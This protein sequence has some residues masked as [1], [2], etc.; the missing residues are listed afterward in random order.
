[1]VHPQPVPSNWSRTFNVWIQDIQVQFQPRVV[2][3][4][5]K[6]GLL[7][8]V[9][10]TVRSTASLVALLFSLHCVR[11]G[12][13]L[14]LPAFIRGEAYAAS[15]VEEAPRPAERGHAS[16]YGSEADGFAWLP[17]ASGEPCNPEA[18]TCAH[19][20]L[21]FGT[22]VEVENLDN[23]RVAILRVNDRGPFLA[24][25][26]ID[27]TARGAR[28]LGFLLAG[29]ARVAVRTAESLLRPRPLAVRLEAMAAG[30]VMDLDTLDRDALRASA[31]PQGWNPAAGFGWPSLKAAHPGG[32]DLPQTPG[33]WLQQK[34]RAYVRES[35][36]PREA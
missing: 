3:R 31:A 2:C 21:P 26:V 29:T 27:V 5:L 7:G 34:E 20:T 11:P 13:R 4:G 22:L 8:H 24:G 14:E 9:R 1:M 19:R 36:V 17:T 32:R 18:L 33:A 23:G 30:P 15:P 25:R 35:H 10:P 28:A 12:F 6:R 16:W